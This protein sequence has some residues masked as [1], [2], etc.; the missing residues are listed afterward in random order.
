ME[1]KDLFLFFQR[2]DFFTLFTNFGL[3]SIILMYVDLSLWLSVCVC[4]CLG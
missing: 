3:D 2:E 4:D 1:K